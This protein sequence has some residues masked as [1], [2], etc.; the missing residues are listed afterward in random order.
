MK[1]EN[2]IFIPTVIVFNV[3]RFHF[4]LFGHSRTK[5]YCI[6]SFI[7]WTKTKKSFHARR[8]ELR[9]KGGTKRGTTVFFFFSVSSYSRPWIVNV[10]P[11][12]F[13]VKTVVSPAEW[14]SES[15]SRSPATKDEKRE[16]EI[17]TVRSSM[18]W[19]TRRKTLPRVSRTRFD[20][21]RGVSYAR[22][23][24]TREEKRVSEIFLFSLPVRLSFLFFFL[25]R[26]RK[27]SAAAGDI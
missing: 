24:P 16:N 15:F 13:R 12:V 21:S 9:R 26:K 1:V 4:T 6:S 22:V 11:F 23:S 3:P 5:T 14:W 7:V 25:F 19:A 10:V 27:N 8:V 18:E 20:L 17:R 2:K